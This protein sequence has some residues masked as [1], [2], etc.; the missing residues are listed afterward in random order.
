L[1]IVTLLT[2]SFA[3]IIPF[4]VLDK[5]LYPYIMLVEIGCLFIILNVGFCVINKW[6]GEDESEHPTLLPVV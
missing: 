5:I 2:L 1:F 3:Y 4:L 6:C